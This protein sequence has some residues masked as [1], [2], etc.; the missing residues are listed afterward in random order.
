MWF[1]FGSFVGRSTGA[2]RGKLCDRQKDHAGWWYGALYFLP[3][4]V[5]N[6]GEHKIEIDGGLTL[7]EY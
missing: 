3:I 5:L 7:T 2:N 1:Y 6:G 4:R